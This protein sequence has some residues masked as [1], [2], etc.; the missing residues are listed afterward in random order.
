MQEAFVDLNWLESRLPELADPFEDVPIYLDQLTTQHFNLPFKTV[1]EV[2]ATILP[3]FLFISPVP[4]MFKIRRERSCG[5]F[6]SLPLTTMLTGTALWLSFGLLINEWSLIWSSLFGFVCATYCNVVYYM[7]SKRNETRNQ[8]SQLF[9]GL[10]IGGS[11]LGLSLVWSDPDYVGTIAAC[12]DIMLAVG[13]A[14]AFGEVIHTGETAHLGPFPMILAAFLT[15]T[16]WFFLGWW[17]IQKPQVYL[18]NSVGVVSNGVAL[19]L[20][21]WCGTLGQKKKKD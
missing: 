4:E 9:M 3:L 8:L 12:N 6:P 18:P 17:F 2:V 13:P 21:V 20:F 7:A 19:W 10:T 16:A 1:L 14:I 15:C 11:S 5:L